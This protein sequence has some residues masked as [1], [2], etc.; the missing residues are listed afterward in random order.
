L[1]ARVD[2]PL[3]TLAGNFSGD[4]RDPQVFWGRC[5][6][7]D[8]LVNRRI[9][10]HGAFI[11]RSTFPTQVSRPS[12]DVNPLQRICTEQT[13]YCIAKSTLDWVLQ[14]AEFLRELKFDRPFFASG[15]VR[16]RMTWEAERKSTPLLECNSPRLYTRELMGKKFL[17]SLPIDDR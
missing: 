4:S 5:Q 12:L 6:Q 10:P 8:R 1:A 3:V 13:S 11:G 17:G 2:L 15:W 9:H 7:G 14:G 16:N